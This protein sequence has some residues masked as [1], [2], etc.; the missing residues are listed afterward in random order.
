MNEFVTA[1]DFSDKVFLWTFEKSADYTD[2][3]G[4]LTIVDKNDC[5]GSLVQYTYRREK[6]PPTL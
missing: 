1:F 2:F 6:C 3:I 4:N 5:I